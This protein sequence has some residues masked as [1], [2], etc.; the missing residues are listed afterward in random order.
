MVR[1]DRTIPWSLAQE[2]ERGREEGREGRVREGERGREGGSWGYAGHGG[3][4]RMAWGW[5]APRAGRANKEV[6]KED[7]PTEDGRRA[8]REVKETR[9]AGG[10]GVLGRQSRSQQRG[11]SWEDKAGVFDIYTPKFLGLGRTH[12]QEVSLGTAGV[13]NPLGRG[14][15]QG[16]R[17]C[18]GAAMRE[19]RRPGQE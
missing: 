6:R 3:P 18:S 11:Q 4:P 14:K 2:T 1:E 19:F 15:R 13:D 8:A 12:G 17:W 10:L 5:G 7:G 16:L 9:I